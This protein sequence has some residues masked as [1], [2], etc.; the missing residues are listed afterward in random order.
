MSTKPEL[1]FPKP[2]FTALLE[3]YK[4]D[5]ETVHT[6]AILNPTEQADGINTCAARLSEALCLA[7]ALATDRAKI[8]AGTKKNDVYPLLGPYNYRLF[9]NLCNHGIARGARDLGE[10]L[11]HHWGQPKSFTSL[12]GAPPEIQDKT[13]VLCFIK[14]P[15]YSGQGHVDVWNKASCVGSGYRN[16]SKVWF[17]ELA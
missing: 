13:G 15:G 14:I 5:A 4:T 2:S 12:E 9:G 16:S 8:R 7:N 3:H 6:C 17:W 10:F 11:Q 1:R